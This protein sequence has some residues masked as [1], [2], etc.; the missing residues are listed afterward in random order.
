VQVASSGGAKGHARARAVARWREGAEASQKVEAPLR[1]RSLSVAG[2]EQR[3]GQGQELG[4]GVL[5]G[6]RERGEGPWRTGGS[7]G[8][9]WRRR[10]GRRRSVALALSRWPANGRGE[11][12]L[13]TAIHITPR[14]FL[15]QGG[16]GG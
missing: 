8:C 2:G 14:R 4:A 10:G 1:L 11:E 7:T 15:R 13:T 16:R 3:G 6:A 12:C 5:Q 9:G